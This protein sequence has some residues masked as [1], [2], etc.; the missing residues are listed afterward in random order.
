MK[1]SQIEMLVNYSESLIITNEYCKGW[2]KELDQDCD[3]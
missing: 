2:S 3:N 1:I